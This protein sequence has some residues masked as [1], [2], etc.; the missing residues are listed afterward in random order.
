MKMMKWLVQGGI[1]LSGDSG[2]L[3]LW[4]PSLVPPWSGDPLRSGDTP[5]EDTPN[6]G[7]LV[8][9]PPGLETP[10]SGDPPVWWPSVWETLQ[11][12]WLQVLVHCQIL[13]TIFRFVLQHYV[14]ISYHLTSYYLILECG[15]VNLGCIKNIFGIKKHTCS[16]CEGLTRYAWQESVWCSVF[17]A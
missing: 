15:Q 6:W 1:H 14:W 16:S 10:R 8:L 7:P 17:R 13:K 5:S 4:G 12:S 9:G 3:P 2:D 11:L